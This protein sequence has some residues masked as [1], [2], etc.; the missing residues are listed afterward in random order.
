MD[1]SSWIVI[2]ANPNTAARTDTKDGCFRWATSGGFSGYKGAEASQAHLI[3][4]LS[5][6]GKSRGTGIVTAPVAAH[7]VPRWSRTM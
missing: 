6:V 3:D 4:V 1:H 7:S 5:A 2:P